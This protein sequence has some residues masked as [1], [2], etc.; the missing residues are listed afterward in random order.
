MM[1]VPCPSCGAIYQVKEKYAGKRFKCQKC[2]TEFRIPE[3]VQVPD[4]A[5]PPAPSSPP[6]KKPADIAA[7]KTPSPAGTSA[8]TSASDSKSRNKLF[9]IAGS[10]AA[11]VVVVIVVIAMSGSGDKDSSKDQV[12]ASNPKVDPKENPNTVTDDSK[13][14]SKDATN[15]VKT[16]DT[17]KEKKEQK[18]QAKPVEKPKPRDPSPADPFI[19]L[20][21]EQIRNGVAGGAAF[22]W[23]ELAMLHH[24]LGDHDEAM[25]C[26]TMIPVRISGTISTPTWSKLVEVVKRTGSKEIADYLVKNLEEG[27]QAL[28][29]KNQFQ[30]IT[31]LRMLMDSDQKQAAL[32][33]MEEW[34]A[35][36][37]QGSLD[38]SIELSHWA[39][40]DPDQIPIRFADNVEFKRQSSTIK[41]IIYRW[42]ERGEHEP[43]IKLA[44]ILDVS[45]QDRI[46]LTA[47]P[48]LIS[49][50]DGKDLSALEQRIEKIAHAGVK[51]SSVQLIAM[52]YHDRGDIDRAIE[53]ALS[54]PTGTRGE[55][56][57]VMAP[58]L[59]AVN[60]DEE[61]YA[62]ALRFEYYSSTSNVPSVGVNRVELI[63]TYLQGIHQKGKLDL[64]TE[65]AN[66]AR[67]DIQQSRN[68][69]KANLLRKL[70]ET[71]SALGDKEGSAKTLAVIQ[72]LEKKVP[73]ILPKQ[74][75]ILAVRKGDHE[76]ARNE[77]M[78]AKYS[79]EPAFRSTVTQLANLQSEQG[80]YAEATKTWLA[81]DQH[82]LRTYPSQRT[83][84][85]GAYQKLFIEQFQ[86]GG[87][88]KANELIGMLGERWDGRLGSIYVAMANATLSSPTKSIPQAKPIT[89][90]K[91]PADRFQY[92]MA[93][94]NSEHPDQ[95]IDGMA[96]LASLGVEAIPSWQRAAQVASNS[97]QWSQSDRHAMTSG[98]YKIWRAATPV[99]WTIN[100]S[101]QASFD[102]PIVYA[103]QLMAIL[104]D[105]TITHVSIVKSALRYLSTYASKSGKGPEVAEKH[106]V[107]LLLTI[108]RHPELAIAPI[109][110]SMAYGAS[111][112]TFKQ[113][114]QLL[115]H[116]SK[117]IRDT[118]LEIV[119][120]FSRNYDIADT[121][122]TLDASDKEASK[123]ALKT[124]I[125]R[126]PPRTLALMD[127]YADLLKSK[128]VEVRVRV[129]EE[130]RKSINGRK[131]DEI[132]NE[133][134]RLR[135]KLVAVRNDPDFATQR[136]VRLALDYLNKKTPTTSLGSRS[137]NENVSAARWLAMARSDDQS[138]KSKIYALGQL[139]VGANIPILR[140][141]LEEFANPDKELRQAA[142][143]ALISGKPEFLAT[144]RNDIEKLFREGTD[145]DMRGYL[146][147][148][149][150]KL[151]DHNA[152]EDNRFD[153]GFERFKDVKEAMAAVRDKRG[154]IGKRVSALDHLARTEAKDPVIVN[155]F[156][157][158]L[159][160]KHYRIRIQAASALQRSGQ[161]AS[162]A[163]DELTKLLDD[164]D[165]EVR[166]RA[167]FALQAVG[168]DDSAAIEGLVKATSDMIPDIRKSAIL[169]LLMAQN[170][171][172]IEPAV[173][174]LLEET[175]SRF[176]IGQV[177]KK[178]PEEKIRLV[179][180]LP[181]ELVTALKSDDEEVLRKAYFVLYELG[182]AGWSIAEHLRDHLT[183]DGLIQ[184]G[185]TQQRL[186]QY[187][188][189]NPA[190]IRVIVEW[191][192]KDPSKLS[193]SMI[194]S[195]SKLSARGELALPMLESVA[196]NKNVSSSIRL[197]AERAAATIKK[198]MEAA[199]DN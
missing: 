102:V 14:T 5:S 64:Y 142:G 172:G 18:E 45:D 98:W 17:A 43:A 111:E 199:K 113:T 33:K 67:D 103:D 96:L 31:I 80:A 121:I 3:A 42:Q 144:M 158:V 57:K 145:R 139:R 143:N 46:F 9:V 47:L 191:I 48:H 151:D 29:H 185:L 122:Q 73:S 8:G 38:L 6:K 10:V 34:R 129:A 66:Q 89:A 69:Y 44:K 178:W 154:S 117:P 167:V 36:T 2:D 108:D 109:A 72:E 21:K 75:F 79:T 76:A 182:S 160:D 106:L 23:C 77:V 114:T 180:T 115:S 1:K 168:A 22:E 181:A 157:S 136:D 127:T 132:N 152:G 24:K 63:C 83:Y 65:I 171:A 193:S 71:E 120:D 155:L 81:Y 54:L 165:D 169:A 52:A 186:Q 125:V 107:Q 176:R 91:P 175:N 187:F 156:K 177:V 192:E 27:L 104:T 184:P 131:A 12:V 37:K 138:K 60:R 137:K 123:E 179:K 141:L 159:R 170:A 183:T 88:D 146:R 188:P 124:L 101:R 150:R 78:Q 32:K 134:P 49:Q 190:A 105:P 166:Q 4:A 26:I 41:G 119:S 196:E 50:A 148:M 85:V 82:L 59:S 164:W 7:N 130:I 194:D 149:L 90:F 61:I 126:V 70:A 116:E 112:A 128:D 95:I 15:P 13:P 51:A 153:S 133:V 173:L 92:G 68:R 161:A 20:A 118:A 140:A 174:S 19:A 62:L 35:S 99:E 147:T 195:L 86:S 189:F 97:E 198:A 197:S 94:L 163:V 40:V 56:Y 39:I 162:I 93:L 84:H 100:S 110:R 16:D 58:S 28:P 11:A 25:A 87:M 55:L 74:D 30:Y 135:I 53:R